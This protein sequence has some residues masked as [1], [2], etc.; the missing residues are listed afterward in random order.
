MGY[1]LIA[2]GSDH[3]YIAMGAK[4]LLDVARNGATD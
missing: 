3:R 2:L 4:A 1:R